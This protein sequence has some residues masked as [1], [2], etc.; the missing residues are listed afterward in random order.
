MSC[1]TGA[2]AGRGGAAQPA[3]ADADSIRI[4]DDAIAYCGWTTICSQR[5]W[6]GDY[7]AWQAAGYPIGS[8]LIERAVAVVIHWRLK[9][10][11]TH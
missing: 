3:A 9:R 11:G 5:A 10:W 7:G 8:G 2:R 6:L 4:L 1:G